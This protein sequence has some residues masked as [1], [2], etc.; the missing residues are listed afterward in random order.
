MKIT[1]RLTWVMTGLSFLVVI[2]LTFLEHRP[3]HLYWHIH[4]SP[5]KCVKAYGQ[6]LSQCI[7]NIIL[8]LI[9]MVISCPVL[10]DR[11]RT[12]TQHLRIGIVFMLGTFC[13]D[14]TVMR[15]TAVCGNEGQQAARTLWGVVEI[16][17]S[18]FVAN[19]P[20]IYGHIRLVLRRR[21]QTRKRSLSRPESWTRS[22]QD[23]EAMDD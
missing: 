2:L 12:W 6:P 22:G 9:L 23:E 16:I 21:E 4:P 14:V 19:V 13:V 5:G 20:T 7:C 10:L 11:G 8:D 15:L 1:I 18:S 17:V 3:F